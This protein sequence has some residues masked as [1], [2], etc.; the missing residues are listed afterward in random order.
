M[1][2]KTIRRTT[3]YLRDGPSIAQRTRRGTDRLDRT[4]GTF[5][6]RGKF[7]TK[8]VGSAQT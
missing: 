4:T 1:A 3:T 5:G 2:I 8:G 6:V 7:S